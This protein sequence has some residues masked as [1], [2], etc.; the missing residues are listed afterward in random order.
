[1]L[2]FQTVCISEFGVRNATTRVLGAHPHICL[3][4]A[5]TKNACYIVSVHCRSLNFGDAAKHDE[6]ANAA[7][8]PTSINSDSNFSGSCKK[9]SESAFP[10]TPFG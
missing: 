2:A 6:T 9:A 1:M 5:G 10:S 7:M 8:A 4:M 3:S